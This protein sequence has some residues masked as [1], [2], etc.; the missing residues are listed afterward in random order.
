MPA[1]GIWDLTRRLKGGEV[2]KLRKSVQFFNCLW[3]LSR[4]FYVQVTVHRNKF[5]FNK[6]KRCTNFFKFIFL[7]RT[8]TWFGHFLCPSSGNFHCTFDTGICH[9]SLMTALK[10]VL[11]RARKLSSNLHDIH[12]C[13]MYSAK[14]LMTGRGTVR[15]MCF[16]IKIN[17][18]KSVHLLVLLKRSL[19]RCSRSFYRTRLNS[20]VKIVTD[21]FS[22]DLSN[23]VRMST[24][25]SAYIYVVPPLHYR[26]FH[27][28]V[29][30]DFCLT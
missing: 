1:N 10:N 29:R 27:D 24:I 14:L 28:H 15:N 16:L 13:R 4:F 30:S 25:V 17:L 23:I 26:Y 11:V 7:S 2:N 8:S 3:R 18:V 20:A 6:T 12:Q 5:L 19:S 21:I 9:A 22:E